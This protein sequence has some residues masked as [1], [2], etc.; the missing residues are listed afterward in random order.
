[1]MD[2]KEG[3]G[4]W[5]CAERL[6]EVTHLSVRLIKRKAPERLRGLTVVQFRSMAFAHLRGGCTVSELAEHLGIA[7]P[8]ASALADRLVRHALMTRR[9]DPGDRRQ[10]TLALTA[11][12][13]RRVDAARH[14]IRRALARVLAPLPPS[15]LATIGAGLEL[16]VG[17]LAEE[18]GTDGLVR[19]VAPAR[20][21]TRKR[22]EGRL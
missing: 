20:A 14:E 6:L 22:P 13:S 12:G 8:T 2:Q 18:A 19:R 15:S 3:I 4:A 21:R 10:V 5:A 7:R 11:L 1:M 9:V 16:L 17:T